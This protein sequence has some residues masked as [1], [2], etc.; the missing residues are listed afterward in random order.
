MEMPEVTHDKVNDLTAR[1]LTCAT[2]ITQLMSHNRDDDLITVNPVLVKDA[3]NLLI[4]A[5]AALDQLIP[6][7]DL[8]P[9]MEILEPP[10]EN[11]TLDRS[12]NPFWADPGVPDA[13]S[14]PNPR[15]CPKCD[16]RATKTVH[17]MDNWLELECPVC[18]TRWKYNNIRKAKWI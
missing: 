12:L 4:E 6:P 11:F 9:L 17:R 10:P 18:G 16:S 7:P 15:T 14:A 13:P 5:A 2:R 3:G 1:M 8:G